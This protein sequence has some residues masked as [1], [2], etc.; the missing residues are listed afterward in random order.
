MLRQYDVRSLHLI[1]QSI[2]SQKALVLAAAGLLWDIAMR[3]LCVSSLLSFSMRWASFSFSCI[4]VRI[5]RARSGS[6][7]RTDLWKT[8][9]TTRFLPHRRSTCHLAACS[10]LTEALVVVNLVHWIRNFLD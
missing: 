5:D 7:I 9:E 2:V 8:L 1:G 6:R 10:W 3:L 4:Q